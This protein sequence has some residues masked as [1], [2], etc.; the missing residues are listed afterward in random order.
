MT[1]MQ[2]AAPIAG[3]RAAEGARP[4]SQRLFVDPY[5]HLFAD[6]APEVTQ[7]FRAIPFFEEHIRLRTRFMDDAIRRALT[8]G[9]RDVVLI[10]AGFDCRALRM[11]EIAAAGARVIEVDHQDQLAEKRRRLEAANVSLPPHLVHAPAD[12]RIPGALEAALAAAGASDPVR[13][14]WVCEGLF[15]YLSY[16]DLRVLAASAGRA[17]APGSLLVAN[18]NRSSL[19]PDL[20]SAA[21]TAAGWTD[22]P[23]P[24]FDE[25]HRTHLGSEPPAGSDAF[26]LFEA[27]R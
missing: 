12:L 14:A 21:F 17:S 9:T 10:G 13:A 26:M 18:Y 1:P 7:L 19:R 2:T 8:A 4:E 25:L 5:A 3:V 20:V 24:A 11:P 23:A 15:G 22:E 16:D 6:A 27:S